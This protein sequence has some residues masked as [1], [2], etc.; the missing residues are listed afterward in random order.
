MA[1]G[2]ASVVII[3]AAIHSASQLIS[4]FLMAFVITVALAPAQ[5]WL[6]RKGLRPPLAF[7][8]T[9]IAM[10]VGIGLTL[11]ILTGSLNQFIQ[12][13]PQYKEQFADLQRQIDDAL[14]SLGFRPPV[15][16]SGPQADTSAIA[17]S[18]AAAAGWLVSAFANFG[19]MLALAAF[20]LL[21]ATAM[22]AKMKAISLP[23]SREPV[24]RFVSNVRSYV[25]VTT[26]VNLLVGVV[27]TVLLLIM[28]VPYAV[29]WGA[30]AFLFGFIPSVGF[31]LSLVGPALMALLVSGPEAAAMVI[32]AFIIIN[33][34]IQN[35]ILPRRM[36]E[37]TD[38]SAAVVFGSLLFWGYILG[39]VGAILSVPM[40]MIVRMSLEF[41]D[42]TRGLAYLMSSGKHPFNGERE[43][44]E[45]V[46]SL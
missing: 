15:I 31:L 4:Q 1:M 37:G 45:D 6:I 25:V 29:L 28:G 9:V 17:S 18:V 46:T 32:I 2:L 40:T 21:E 36:G 34:G 30:L 5:G 11:T 10:V 35:I 27:D 42:T 41:S 8:V 12:D 38:L 26:W 3:L 19:F 43:K 39:P 20:M 7:L 16:G 23:A 13:L 33:G 44:T 14:A 22:P 24:N